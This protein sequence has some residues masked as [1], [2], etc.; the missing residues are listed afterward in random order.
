MSTTK[1]NYVIF[2]CN[3]ADKS[4]LHVL[5]IVYRMKELRARNEIKPSA[6]DAKPKSEVIHYVTPPRQARERS[7]T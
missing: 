1:T 3:V 7:H 4:R 5:V 6:G 2:C